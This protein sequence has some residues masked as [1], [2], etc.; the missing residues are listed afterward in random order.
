MGDNQQ[1][2]RSK[3]R[4]MKTVGIIAEYNPFHN[5]HCLQIQEIRRRFPGAGIIV[6]MSG[7]FTQRGTVAILDKWQRAEAAVRHGASLVLELPTVF[8]TRSAQYFAGG[9]VS[10]LDR[11][12]AVDVIAFGSECENLKSLAHLADKIDANQQSIAMKNE[13]QIGGSYAAA[14]TE[15]A[16][17][18]A[19]IRQPNVI[20]AVEYL[21]AIRRFH[22]NLSPMPLPRFSAGH[23]DSD[24]PS[25]GDCPIASA[26][27]IRAALARG[28]E[29]NALCA[30]PKDVATML[31][32]AHAHGYAD[33]EHLFR[34]LLAKLLNA[35]PEYLRSIL[36]VN[37]G[38]EHRIRRAAL[39]ARSYA[40]II[41]AV[42]S[43]RYPLARI[44]R[45][46]MHILFSLTK[47]TANRF[48]ETG[49]LYAR[50][51][52]FNDT[53]RRILRN[54]RGQTKI[55]VITK[56]SRFLPAQASDTGQ[57]SPAQEMLVF[58]LK[59]TAFASLA[60]NPVGHPPVNADYLISPIYLPK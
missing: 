53:G 38:I 46:L 40:E 7:S 6:A 25:V 4:A 57:L 22:V 49:P 10:L 34:P 30:V 2:E 55:P 11:L 15:A 31:S 51:L 60:S 12:G 56:L 20:L 3:E 47:K 9:G 19:D 42:H 59:A 5:G 52:A 33:M 58:D 18:D 41:E 48:D 39:S 45:L 36:G 43:K 37:E 27:A 50:V 32:N 1:D 23:H 44:R 28:N 29:H 24:I 17:P 54:I 8:S 26:S 16:A 14:I 21:R 13:L 35:S